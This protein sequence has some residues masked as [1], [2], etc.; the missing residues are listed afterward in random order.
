[1][2]CN[3]LYLTL[4][5]CNELLLAVISCNKLYIAVITQVRSR[6]PGV[7]ALVRRDTLHLDS[8]RFLWGG[9]VRQGENGSH[10]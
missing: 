9:Q 2:C 10:L 7:E 8:R 1:M 4:I 3:R 5:S 6:Y